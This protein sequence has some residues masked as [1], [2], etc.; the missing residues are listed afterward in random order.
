MKPP[1]R[2]LGLMMAGSLLPLGQVAGAED[3]P[4]SVAGVF[5]DHAVLQR[6]WMVLVWGTGTPGARV[7]V[8]FDHVGE[9][10]MVAREDELAAPVETPA[11]ALEEFELADS[12]GV[13][14]PAIATIE[15]AEVVVHSEAVPK[16]VAVRYACRGAPPNANLYNRVGLPASP[17]CSRLDLLPWV[18]PSRSALS[19]Q[20]QFPCLSTPCSMD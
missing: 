10:L 18:A 7:R 2:T 12:E 16:P 6:H 11:A 4:L 17:F 1:L 8:Q 14:H 19:L 9:G 5:S 20:R 15:G 3:G 13:W